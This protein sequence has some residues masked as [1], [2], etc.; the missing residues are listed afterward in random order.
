M[1]NKDRLRVAA[2]GENPSDAEYAVSKEYQL[3]D[4]DMFRL[5]RGAYLV[6]ILVA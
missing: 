1:F 2:N 4:D 6:D 3:V 5:F